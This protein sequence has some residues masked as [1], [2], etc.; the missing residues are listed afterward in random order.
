MPISRRRWTDADDEELKRLA[1]DGE[2]D[3]IAIARK[4]NRSV[5]ATEMRAST[6]GIQL[7]S[8]VRWEG[9][10]KARR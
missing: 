10:E 6:L 7:P 2:L 4:L 1:A 5:G 9:T 3:R 8:T